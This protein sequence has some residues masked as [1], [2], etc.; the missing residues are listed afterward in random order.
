MFDI[1]VF[2]E[3]CSSGRNVDNN[4]IREYL[5][6]FERVIIWGS[7]G[8]GKA[9]GNLIERW[10][11]K[12][13][14]YWDQ[15]FEEIGKIGDHP[16]KAP[17]S[18]EYDREKSLLMYSIPNH[19]IMNTLMNLAKKHGYQHIIRGDI[20]YSGT[21][22]PYKLGSSPSAH[23][24]WMK[25]ECRSVICNRL[26]K[27]VVNRSEKHCDDDRIDLTYNCFIINSI[28]NLSCTHCVQYINNYKPERR[29]N[30][31]TEI[32]CRDIDIWLDEIID[33]VGT[34]SVMGGETFMH[35]DISKIVKCFSKHKNFGFV[36]F[37][38][39]GLYPIKP[40]Q[41]EGIDDQR[42]IIALGAYQ[43]VASEK[44]LEIYQKNVELVKSY[45][46]AYTESRYLPTWVVPSGIY[47][48]SDDVSYMTAKKQACIMPPRNLQI[49]DGKVHV[50]DRGVALY[51][52]GAVDYPED[53]YVLTQSGSLRERR[54]RFRDFVN[55]P[56]YYTCGHCGNKPTGTAPSAIQGRIDVF[57]PDSYS[58]KTWE[59]F[60]QN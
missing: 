8:L 25:N 51:A 18:V 24:C 7:A 47:K 36:S 1:D 14:I 22:C 30:V 5:C 57:D 19:V 35:P 55:R 42:I 44:Q 21:I 31:P 49:R 43:H 10:G 28:C 32:I 26:K 40:E 12:E 3:D 23:Q 34:I 45:G 54:Q 46:I 15:R 59:K 39:N 41:L 2:Y 17:F 38:T 33:S 9:I 6:S 56:F 20:F 50:C 27:I 16:V 37:P 60:I 53:Y 48:F 52:M 11:V 13:V 4:A 29:V 58:N